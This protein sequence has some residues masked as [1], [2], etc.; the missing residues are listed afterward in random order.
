MLNKEFRSSNLLFRYSTFKI[1]YQKYCMKKIILSVVALFFSGYCMAQQQLAFPFQGGITAMTQFFKDSIA[2]SPDIIKSKATGTV[3]FKFTADQK[4]T[5]QK[6]IIYYADDAILAPPLIEA[7]R[8][9]THHWVV[10]YNEKY[11]DFI[12]S[13]AISFNPPT[14]G[15]PSPQKS[16]YNFYL[17]HKPILSTNQVPLDNVTLLPAVLVKYSID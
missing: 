6:L 5:I 12:I 8:K 14:Q 10:P 16:V 17:K 11:H 3:V 1:G 4:G 7:L 9:S 2:V 15:T 13:F